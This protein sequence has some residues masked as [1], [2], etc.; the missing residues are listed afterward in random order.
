MKKVFKMLVLLFLISK[1]VIF[2]NIL[3]TL[4]HL[5]FLPSNHVVFMIEE[6]ISIALPTINS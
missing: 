2:E 4:K 1:H 5:K 3:L 6:F